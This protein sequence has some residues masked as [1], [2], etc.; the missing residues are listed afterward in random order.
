MLSQV[1]SCIKS[2]GVNIFSIP[3]EVLINCLV[4]YLPQVDSYH[5]LA[6]C[7]AWLFALRLTRTFTF[8]ENKELR[9]FIDDANYRLKILNVVG[10]GEDHSEDTKSLKKYRKLYLSYYCGVI[11]VEDID[12]FMQYGRYFQKF[13]QMQLEKMYLKPILERYPHLTRDY[14]LPISSRKLNLSYHEIFKLFRLKIN[15]QNEIENKGDLIDEIYHANNPTLGSATKQPQSLAMLRGIK[16]IAISTDL[17]TMVIDI[18]YE[19]SLNTVYLLDLH[20]SIDV[21]LL[22]GVPN[23]HVW[24]CSGLLSTPSSIKEE[25]QINNCPNILD[26]SNL[27][28][29]LS[30]WITDCDGISDVTALTSTPEVALRSCSQIKDFLPLQH[31][32]TLRLYDLGI[33]DVKHLQKVTYLHLNNCQFITDISMLGLVK[34]LNVNNCDGITSFPKPTGINQDWIFENL[35]I[36]DEYLTALSNLTTLELINCGQLRDLRALGTVSKLVLQNFYSVEHYPEPQG[37]YQKW[38]FYNCNI[39]KDTMDCSKFCNMHQLTLHG[40]ESLTKLSGLRHI[41]EVAILE[42][43]DLREINDLKDI[44]HVDIGNC[45]N[46][47]IM[48][49]INCIAFLSVVC[50]YRLRELLD[51]ANIRKANIWVCDILEEL[52]ALAAVKMLHLDSCRCIKD[53]HVLQSVEELQIKKC[54]NVELMASMLHIVGLSKL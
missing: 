14:A 34:N 50:C 7:K 23:L 1:S 35:S 3:E 20:Q 47:E 48:A 22:E 45:N 32:F 8:K 36:T 49:K 2:S 10:C 24:E 39:R 53:I 46:L 51:F 25:V 37:E 27:R 52:D 4:G 16:G 12:F 9:S 33:S 19:S 43:N 21:S 15:Q 26:I 40:C 28:N 42:C 17:E 18:C 30:V 29:S 5:F 13:S 38:R 54:P 6:L 44:D 11:A 31:A 41:R